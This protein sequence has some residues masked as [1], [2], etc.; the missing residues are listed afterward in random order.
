MGCVCECEPSPRRRL[1]ELFLVLGFMAILATVCLV[2]Y[3]TIL[4]DIIVLDTLLVL[5]GFIV[6]FLIV[7]IIEFFGTPKCRYER[8]D[9]QMQQ[10]DS[11][12][13]VNDDVR[14]SV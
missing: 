6:A 14:I 3:N 7:I 5:L 9:E 8:E 13:Q 12:L 2:V 4:K 10:V 1:F 11:L